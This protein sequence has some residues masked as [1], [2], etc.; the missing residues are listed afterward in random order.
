M[1]AVSHSVNVDGMV[2]L[3]VGGG[4]TNPTCYNQTFMNV[5][6]SG[7]VGTQKPQF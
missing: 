1:N 4:D 3:F 2:V 7:V 6:H 5:L